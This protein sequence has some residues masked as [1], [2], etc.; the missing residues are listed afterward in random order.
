[1]NMWWA[2]EV[3]RNG[4]EGKNENE[5]GHSSWIH[6]RK[7]VVKKDTQ[8]VEAIMRKFPQKISKIYYVPFTV[9]RSLVFY[10]LFGRFELL[11]SMDSANRWR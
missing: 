9:E 6:A 11:E 4:N 3:K 1:M 5:G 8:E 2:S 7:L 10:F